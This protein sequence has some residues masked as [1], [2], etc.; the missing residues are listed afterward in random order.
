MTPVF[1]G[2]LPKGVHKAIDADLSGTSALMLES[3]TKKRSS[4]KLPGYADR[5]AYRPV[6][7]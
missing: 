1:S 3:M 7:A 6:T 2:C 4:P 5:P